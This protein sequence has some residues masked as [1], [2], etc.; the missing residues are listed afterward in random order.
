MQIDK[1]K[2]QKLLSLNDEDLKKKISDV[3]NTSNFE[4]KD[5]ENLDKALKN[6]KDIKKA[7]GNIDEES[8]KK[9]VSALGVEKIEELKKNIKN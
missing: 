1:D 8:L 5:K 9:A 3:L 6:M 7:I 2:L 4:K